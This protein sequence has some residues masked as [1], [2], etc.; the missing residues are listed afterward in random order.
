MKRRPSPGTPRKPLESKPDRTTRRRPAV[1]S[2]IG[3]AAVSAIL[4]GLG[5]PASSAPRSSE[6]PAVAA[7][8]SE[9][10]AHQTGAKTEVRPGEA[11]VAVSEIEPGAAKQPLVLQP[12][13][14]EGPVAPEEQV[15]TETP[16][17][18]ETPGA[19]IAD[20]K[21]ASQAFEAAAGK[22]SAPGAR[23]DPDTLP[24]MPNFT[25]VALGAALGELQARFDEFAHNEW[26]QTGSAVVTGKERVEVV[27]I[28]G[29]PTHRFSICIDSSA[30]EIR[31]TSGATVLAA[32]P[33]GTRTASNIYDIQQHNGKWLVVGHSF[34]DAAAC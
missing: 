26:M 23:P 33:P 27:R 16:A 15:A 29:V 34:P 30:I 4:V 18:P 13:A 6:S 25:D 10:Q 7:V 8:V 32:V 14:P 20:L 5:A 22:A 9:Q 1:A 28:G 19:P 11:P 12:A 24:A 17:A 2:A 21:R 31:D 3:V